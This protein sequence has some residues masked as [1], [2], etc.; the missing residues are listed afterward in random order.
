MKKSTEPQRTLIKR[1]YEEFY[2]TFGEGGVN[3]VTPLLPSEQS[4]FNVSN[5]E[6]VTISGEGRVGVVKIF[7]TSRLEG[8]DKIY[9]LFV[10]FEFEDEVWKY[11][12]HWAKEREVKS[13]KAQKVVQKVTSNRKPSRKKQPSRS[14]IPAPCR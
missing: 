12:G 4:Q 10:K 13:P 1:A 6:T 5:I 2:G 8:N 14:H 9:E 11:R 7:C 3:Q